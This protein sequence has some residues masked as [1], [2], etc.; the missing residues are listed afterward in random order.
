MF[1]PLLL[2]F[3]LSF[4]IILW[5]VIVHLFR[6]IMNPHGSGFTMTAT[7]NWERG[8]KK[9]KSSN[10]LNF[11]LFAISSSN[12]TLFHIN[13]LTMKYNLICWYRR[14][15]QSFLFTFL[16]FIH[17]HF[18]PFL[19]GRFNYRSQNQIRPFD[20]TKNWLLVQFNWPENWLA[21]KLIKN[22]LNL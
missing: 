12:H 21:K 11:N 2:S 17:F 15:N 18:H 7:F 3:F 20:L 10:F 14:Q 13:L 4:L 1:H 9:T 16:S 5:V 22:R 6:Q 19:I 8:P